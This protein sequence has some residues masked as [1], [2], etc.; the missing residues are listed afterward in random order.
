MQIRNFAAVLAATLLM[1][2]ATIALAADEV[3]AEAPAFGGSA[4]YVSIGGVY[5]IENAGGVEGDLSNSGGYDLRAGYK[6]GNMIAAE[7]EWQA[8]GNFDR[9]ALEPVT[10]NDEPSLEAR[11]LSLN[12]RF[13]PL[14][15]RFQPYGLLGAGWMNVQADRVSSYSHESAFAMRFG[16][17]VAAYLTDRI[18]LAVEAAYIL[19]LTG[20]LGGGDSFDLIPI[21]ASVFFRFK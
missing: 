13:S 3:P 4:P 1:A 15:G 8:F 17:G 16:L 14:S 21:T 12:G 7:V 6:F 11:M 20:N 2:N 10:G 18:G 5:G 9:D 19:P